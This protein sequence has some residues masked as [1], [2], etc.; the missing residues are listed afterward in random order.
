MEKLTF[1][2]Y[3]AS[4]EKLREAIQQ[5]PVRQ[6]TYRLRKYCK[7]PVGET[8][9]LKEYIALKPK[10]EVIVEWHYADIDNPTAI[11]MSFKNV[12]GINLE[13][14][15]KAFWSDERLQKWLL[16]NTREV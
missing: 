15:F 10:Q 2:D 7:F 6:A 5:T 9:E 8:K 16:R 12:D 1:K 11:S 13:Q 4:K 3:L 14:K